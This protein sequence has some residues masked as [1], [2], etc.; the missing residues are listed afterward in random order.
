MGN[1]KVY[2]I[3]SINQKYYI[4][5][6]NDLEDR[7][8]RHNTNRNKY[9]KGRGP[10]E[11]VISYDTETR[12]EAVKIESYLKKLKNSELAIKYLEKLSMF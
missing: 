10:W 2:I 12:S 7:L 6:T 8:K 3:K 5:Q 11:I 4:G 9:T 1:Y